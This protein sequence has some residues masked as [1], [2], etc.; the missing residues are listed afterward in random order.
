MISIYIKTT[1]V[2]HSVSIHVHRACACRC[3]QEA[4]VAEDSVKEEK[5]YYR[6]VFTTAKN[7]VSSIAFLLRPNQ[8]AKCEHLH[9]RF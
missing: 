5:Y 8:E 3:K 7:L 2:A 9:H 6:Q 1:K 4:D